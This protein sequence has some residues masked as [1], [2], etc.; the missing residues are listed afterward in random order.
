MSF[1]G[2]WFCL[3]LSVSKADTE[4]KCD[5]TLPWLQNFWITT[6]WSLSNDSGKGNE[7]GKKAIGLD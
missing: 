5:F 4:K 3:K 1:T 2:A 7:K 6:I